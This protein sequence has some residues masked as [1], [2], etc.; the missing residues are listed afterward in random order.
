MKIISNK[1]SRKLRKL[2][3]NISDK[4]L[5]YYNFFI[6]SVE[7]NILDFCGS[8]I[9]IE[10]NKVSYNALIT[11]RLYETGKYKNQDVIEC[12]EPDLLKKVITGKKGWGLWVDQWSDG[13]AEGTFTKAEILKQFAD[14]NIE[15]PESL[16]KDF[17]YKV[18]SKY[19]IK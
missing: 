10:Y 2:D 6:K 4:L 5:N 14:N 13:I 15:I 16:L 12:A 18:Y 11:Y 8:N 9:K 3:K 17:N 1:S 19:K 7:A